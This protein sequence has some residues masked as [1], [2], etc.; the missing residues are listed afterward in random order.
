M[1]TNFNA[2]RGMEHPKT[3]RCVKTIITFIVVV[4]LLIFIYLA[5]KAK[6]IKLSDIEVDTSEIKDTTA[7]QSIEVKEN[8]GE[9]NWNKETNIYNSNSPTKEKKK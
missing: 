6:R 2:N 3:S 4:I 1:A 5:I 7:K 8:N 9:I